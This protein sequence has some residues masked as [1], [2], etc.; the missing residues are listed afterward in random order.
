MRQVSRLADRNISA[1]DRSDGGGGSPHAARMG[2][3]HDKVDT[4]NEGI[5]RDPPCDGTEDDEFV[6]LL[7]VPTVAKLRFNH[8]H[9]DQLVLLVILGY[10]VHDID[11]A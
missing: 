6:R 4:S 7:V 3:E 9:V 1:N 8:N 11:V 10:D 5:A 2:K